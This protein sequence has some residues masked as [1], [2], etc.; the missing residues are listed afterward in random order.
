MKSLKNY[1]TRLKIR[2]NQD[3]LCAVKKPVS[4]MAK[5]MKGECRAG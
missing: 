5:L 1:P 3:L 4:D 2:K